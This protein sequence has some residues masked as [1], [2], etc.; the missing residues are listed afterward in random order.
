[1]SAFHV[2]FIRGIGGATHGL[3]TMKQLEQAVA[4]AG[5][6]E[7]R[8]VLAT[9]NFVVRSDLPAAA[10]AARFDQAMRRRG[11]ER[12]LVMRTPAQL[13]RVLAAGAD[14]PAVA[15]RPSSVLVHFFGKRA[16]AGAVE[17]IA[18]K[19]TIEDVFLL[20]GELVVDFSDRVSDSKLKLEFFERCM[21]CDGTGRNWNT[22][23]KV[24]AAAVALGWR[25]R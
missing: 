7:V 4:R 24:L 1:V 6:G 17:A 11:L 19:A 2:V 3:V 10:I 20:G 14:H 5:V 25:A 12:P 22:V 23:L 15:E 18:A 21:G 9:G 8:S 13:R 16:T